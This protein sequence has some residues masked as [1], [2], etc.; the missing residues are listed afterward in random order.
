[1]RA[2]GE[3]KKWN[4]ISADITTDGWIIRGEEDD[5]ITDMIILRRPSI[6][7]NNEDAIEIDFE[8]DDSAVDKWLQF[9]LAKG[10]DERLKDNPY[11][12]T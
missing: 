2:F 4:E 11:L 3:I 7:G 5:E 9:L 8:I 6:Y 12:E 10:C 1:M